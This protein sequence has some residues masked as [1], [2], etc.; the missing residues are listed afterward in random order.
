[1]FKSRSEKDEI[2]RELSAR[3]A[4]LEQENAVYHA[5]FESVFHY[6]GSYPNWK[7]L[8]EFRSVIS[9]VGIDVQKISAWHLSALDSYLRKI[10]AATADTVR[11]LGLTDADVSMFESDE[12]LGEDLLDPALASSSRLSDIFALSLDSKLDPSLGS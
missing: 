6:A 10:V 11:Q 3:V 5:L 4:V 7:A 9:S 8:Q 12:A 2:I 1:M